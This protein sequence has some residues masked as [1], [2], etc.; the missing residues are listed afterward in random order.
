VALPWHLPNR[1]IV[2]AA[3][4]TLL[5]AVVVV[6]GSVGVAASAAWNGA[7]VT[8]PG[9][10]VVPQTHLN[11]CGPA[12]LATL[13]TWLGNPRTEAELLQAADVGPTGVT[14]SEFARLAH[15]IGLPGTWY[16]VQPAN[17]HLVPTPFVA[18]LEGAGAAGLG[19]L[20][21]VAAVS[22]GYVTVADPASGAHVSPLRAFARRFTGRVYVLTEGVQW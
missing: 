7:P 15:Q 18:H 20:V 12:T 9:L 19:H 16:Q 3:L 8:L 4:A 5:L 17:L 10:Q 13:S 22:H 11:S 2:R 6:P 21:A 14:L 1:V